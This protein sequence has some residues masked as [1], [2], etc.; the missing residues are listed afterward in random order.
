MSEK[1]LVIG[2]G[3]PGK[4]YLRTRHNV[5]FHVVERLARSSDAV[6]RS[7]KNFSYAWASFPNLEMFLCKPDTYMNNSGEIF[8]GVFAISKMKKQ[9]MVVI[10]DNS[11]L[12]VGKIRIK[13]DG[14]STTHNGLKSIVAYLGSHDFLRVYI[15][16]GTPLFKLSSHV[17]GRW[18]A[19]ENPLYE[20]AFDR[21]TQA[22]MELSRSSIDQIQSQYN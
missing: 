7:R 12:P 19:E 20:E 2:L 14:R 3:N 22:V 6:F 21:A 16:I 1:L 10:T 9:H 11:D 15:G 5:G 18:T 17:L 13:P 8:P 4:S